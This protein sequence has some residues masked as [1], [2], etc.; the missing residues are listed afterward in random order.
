MT[1]PQV[2][3]ARARQEAT[4]LVGS[5]FLASWLAKNF[6]VGIC[7][8]SIVLSPRNSVY[9]RLDTKKQRWNSLLYSFSRFL[10]V[11]AFR[12]PYLLILLADIFPAISVPHGYRGF[13]HQY[14]LVAFWGLIILWSIDWTFADIC[15]DM[16]FEECQSMAKQ[17]MC[18]S[19]EGKINPVIRNYC[20]KSCGACNAWV[21]M[22][23]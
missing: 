10:I 2:D 1:G 3:R 20:Q 18:N 12:F 14:R 17:G 6:H 22:R 13:A 8:I 15:D 4:W 19:V 16:Y 11:N 5:S 23:K 21:P 7:L 9:Y